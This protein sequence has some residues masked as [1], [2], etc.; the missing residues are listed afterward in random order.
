MR[1]GVEAAVAADQVA[2]GAGLGHRKVVL[3]AAAGAGQVDVVALA[4]A[5][6]LGPALPVRVLDDAEILERGERAIDRRGVDRGHPAT[7]APGD[8]LGRDV[9]VRPEDLLDDR[10][11]L[12]RQAV[13][14]GPQ[15]TDDLLDLAHASTLLQR[16]CNA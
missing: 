2:E 6:V 16:C 15:P 14:A 10:L 12:R 4:G 7:D 5:V 9:P 11:A 13:T 3:G 8:G 1:S